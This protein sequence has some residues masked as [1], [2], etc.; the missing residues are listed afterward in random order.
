MNRT[1]KLS[2][3][4]GNAS[5]YEKSLKVRSSHKFKEVKCLNHEDFFDHNQTG[6]DHKHEVNRN[7]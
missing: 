5:F 3:S 2:S 1:E 6:F 7:N 4:K